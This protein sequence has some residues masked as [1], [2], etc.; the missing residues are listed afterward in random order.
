LATALF[1]GARADEGLAVISL[2][3]K[4]RQTARK[5]GLEVLPA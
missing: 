2:D 1:L 5:L 3:E 4:M